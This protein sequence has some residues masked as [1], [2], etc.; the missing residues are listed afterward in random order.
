MPLAIP[1][2]DKPLE[3]RDDDDAVEDPDNSAA[4]EAEGNETELAEIAERGRKLFTPVTPPPL[5]KMPPD[6]TY[7]M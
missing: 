4:R 2:P 1:L 6:G 3:P 5:E 7:E